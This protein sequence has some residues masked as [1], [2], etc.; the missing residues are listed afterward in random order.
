MAADS[1]L[2]LG[3]ND[4]IGHLGLDALCLGGGYLIGSV[5]WGYLFARGCG[6]DIRCEGSGNIGATNVWRVMGR[7][8]GLTTFALDFLKVPLA[9]LL[10][11][12]LIRSRLPV[13]GCSREL[14]RLLAFL[15]AVLGHNFPV[16]LGF[17]GGKGVATSAGG[18]LALMPLPFMVVACAWGIGFAA[19]RIVSL[20][21]L[22]AAVL[23]P[24][25]VWF[26]HRQDRLFQALALA[27]ALMTIWRHRANIGRLVQGTEHQ[28][29][30]KEPPTAG[31]TGGLS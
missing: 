9:L 8:W 18:M 4:A 28:W 16:W 31:K 14:A 6:L 29:K 26:F 25:A 12:F 13:E 20:A 21:S 22:V 5:P 27:L 24:L 15:G 3:M 30:R 23:F 10:V 19:L 17:R 7:G 1:G 11:A 2:I